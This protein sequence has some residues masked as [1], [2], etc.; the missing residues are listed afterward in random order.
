M[1]LQNRFFTRRELLQRTGMGMGAVALAGLLG[2]TSALQADM[3]ASSV[4]P[5]A[6]KAAAFSRQ[7]QA[8]VASV[9]E[10]RP[11]ACRH[12]RSETLT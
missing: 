1:K 9:H 7:S 12:V 10:W 3:S 2:D 11:I 4:N 6:P 5:L 8:R